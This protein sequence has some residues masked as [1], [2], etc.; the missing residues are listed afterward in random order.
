MRDQSA[1]QS[2]R[3]EG[4]VGTGPDHSQTSE[5]EQ[6]LGEALRELAHEFGNLIFPL[7]MMLELQSRAHALDPQ[8]VTQILQGHVAELTRITLRLRWIGRC[9]SGRI[10]P[11]FEGLSPKE[12]LAAVLQ[13]ERIAAR[14]PQDRVHVELASAPARFGGDADLLQQALV[15]LVD[16]ALRFGAAGGKVEVTALRRGDSVEI[17][18]RDHGPGIAPELQQKMFEPFVHGVSRLD[19]ASGQLGCGLAI[20]KRVAAIHGGRAELRRSSAEGSE[21]A[22]CIPAVA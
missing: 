12:L 22:L 17:L 5:F 21:F 8:E 3:D 14:A 20:V 2:D 9:L 1:R 6:R 15:E 16:N 18:V 13:N 7:Q 11:S 4:T 19:I 10:E